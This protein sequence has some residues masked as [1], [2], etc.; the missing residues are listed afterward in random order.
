MLYAVTDDGS[1]SGGPP[2]GSERRELG[3]V[4]AKFR[5]KFRSLDDLVITY[6]HDI[7]QGG[8][9]IGSSSFLPVGTVVQL[10]VELPD[11]GEPAPIIAR[12]AYVLGEDEA[13]A[14]GRST[15]MGMEFLDTGGNDVAGRI[16]EYLAST[17]GEGERPDPASAPADVLIVDDSESY[18]EQAAKAMRAEGHR[19]TTAKNGLEALGIALRQTPDVILSDVNMPV[20]DGWQFIR[21]VRSRPS[22]ASVPVVFLT[23]LGGES[24]RLKGYQLGV[25]D[26]IPKPFD[27]QEL[28]LRVARILSRSRKRPTTSAGRNALRGDLGQVSLGSVLSFIQVERRTGLMLVLAEDRIASLHIRQGDIVQVDLPPDR[29][30]LEGIDRVFEL[31]EW[32]AGRFEFSAVDIAVPDAVRVPTSYI[33]MEHARRQDEGRR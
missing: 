18:R 30:H 12:V 27:S 33:L 25:D 11:G 3:R 6:T 32:S 8:L 29:D 17:L 28:A 26:Y 5:V 31:L 1:S 20:M 19:V 9:F 22:I 7:S 2:R 13:K 10:R 23:T 16:A 4:A 15:G 24:E 21:M 14:R